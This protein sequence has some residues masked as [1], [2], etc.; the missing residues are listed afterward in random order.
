MGGGALEGHTLAAYDISLYSTPNEGS[1]REAVRTNI[2][3]ATFPTGVPVTIVADEL[4]ESHNSPGG[5]DPANIYGISMESAVNRSTMMANLEV[6]DTLRL[7]ERPSP[8]KV[9]L[10][11]FFATDGAGT[12][13]V[14]T[15]AA[16]SGAPGNL[17]R[18]AGTTR[19]AFDT[20]AAN[21]NCEGIDVLDANG[22]RLGDDLLNQGAGV[23]VL[24]RFV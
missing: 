3:A 19:W 5:V 1:A 9:F 24:F 21:L 23:A 13:V 8:D 12:E 10:A 18:V 11:R 22:F 16:V 14:P 15:F 7:V 4:V 6:E 20:G 2:T 17:V